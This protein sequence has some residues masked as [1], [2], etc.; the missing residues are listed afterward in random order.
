MLNLLWVYEDR[1]LDE[2]V[3]WRASCLNTHVVGCDGRIH[4]SSF[5]SSV[6]SECISNFNTQPR[7]SLHGA[8]T[9]FHK[10]EQKWS[11]VILLLIF[12]DLLLI[13]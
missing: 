3:G 5:E 4:H 9:T 11:V 1:G 12:F 7:K 10:I 13:H 2:S 8:D 6:G